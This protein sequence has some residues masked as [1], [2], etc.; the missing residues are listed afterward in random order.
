MGG[1]RGRYLR[2]E[3]RWWGLNDTEL[4]FTCQEEITYFDVQTCI[5]SL[6]GSEGLGG[7]FA[8]LEGLGAIVVC[9]SEL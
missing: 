6:G 8:D 7:D 1:R 5:H 2:V 4:V 3:R 9:G